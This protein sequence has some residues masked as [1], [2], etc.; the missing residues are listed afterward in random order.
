VTSSLRLNGHLNETLAEFETSLVPYHRIS[1]CLP[2]FSP[3]QGRNNPSEPLSVAEIVNELFTK[4]SFLV[5]SNPLQGKFM[6]LCMAFRG[7]V[8][9]KDISAGVAT[10]T[11]KRTI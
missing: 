6:A 2:S 3:I 9:P 11:T 4:E 7:D 5:N 10:I 1:N 8:A